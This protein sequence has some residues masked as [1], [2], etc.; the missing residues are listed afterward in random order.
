MTKNII[1]QQ[2]RD[3][4]PRLP[5]RHLVVRELHTRRDGT[6]VQGAAAIVVSFGV[7]QIVTFL[8]CKIF[9][10]VLIISFSVESG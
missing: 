5:P 7:N 10:N 1:A 9:M 2:I 8:F 4:R 3:N 6:P